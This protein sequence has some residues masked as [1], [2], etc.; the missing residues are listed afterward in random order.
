MVFGVGAVGRSVSASDSASEGRVVKDVFVLGSEVLVVGVGDGDAG[1]VD[2]GCES[3]LELRSFVLGGVWA[4][5]DVG[6]S[7]VGGTQDSISPGCTGCGCG[8]MRSRRSSS[9]GSEIFA[10]SSI[11]TR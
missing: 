6:I 8:G 5:G 1:G 7:T 2:D 3:V 11:S 9:S 4:I 10:A